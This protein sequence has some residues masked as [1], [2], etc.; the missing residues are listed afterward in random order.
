MNPFLGVLLHAIGG[1]SSASFYVPI[2][3]VQRWAWETYWVTLGFVAWIV[4]P[5]IGAYLTTSDLWGILLN[6]PLKN[7]LWTYLF[8]VMW[9]IGGL[10]CGLSLRYLGLSLGQSL[11]LGFC[12]AFGTLIPPIFAGDVG[13]LFGTTSGLVVMAGIVVCLAGISICGYAGALKERQLTTAQKKEAIKDF[14][15]IK[16]FS[17]AI[18][19]GVMSAS[20]AYAFEAGKPIAQAALEAGTSNIYQNNPVLV[21]ALAGG[22][23]TNVIC[24]LFLNLKNKT[25]SDYVARPDK[26]LL[27]NYLLA[28]LSGAMWYGQ[29]FFYGMGTTKMGRYDFASWSIHMAFIIVFSN[30]WGIYLNEWKL[31]NRRTKSALLIGILILIVSTFI[32]G[33]G[34]RIAT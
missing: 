32:I 33:M 19:G 14:A 16:G 22:F 20:M 27:K 1:F 11:S 15:L 4:M 31:V 10:S 2:N 5:L 23:T 34:N 7:V 29:F 26:T 18:F 13:T 8:G 30:I 21:V 17:V 24:C 12:A 25:I 6:C 28:F 3:K 9:G